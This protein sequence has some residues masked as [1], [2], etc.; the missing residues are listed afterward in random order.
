MSATNIVRD[1][2]AARRFKVTG[3]DCQNEVRALKAAVGP[4]AGGEDKL[5]FD[6]EAGWMELA[7]DVSVA[8]EAIEAAVAATG[9]S[10]QAW[11]GEESDAC[12]S[13]AG[14]EALTA[15][16]PTSA[17]E[18]VVL[19]IHGMDCGDEV[20]T[21]KRELVGIVAEE[22]LSFDLINARS[23]PPA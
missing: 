10:A 20:A 18:T 15:P 4:L 14:D 12:K 7:P 5:S 23:P 3:L 22:R 19:K 6:T 21:L 2:G 13:C 1:A 17:P 16:A 9:M 11:P 8:D